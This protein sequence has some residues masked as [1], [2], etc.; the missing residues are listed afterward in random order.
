MASDYS[1]PDKLA[2]NGSQVPLSQVV[3]FHRIPLYPLSSQP[4]D[5]RGLL[6]TL[7]R[8]EKLWHHFRFF[9]LESLR[10]RAMIQVVS[11]PFLR[12]LALEAWR[13]SPQSGDG[14]YVVHF[15]GYRLTWSRIWWQEAEELHVTCNKAPSVLRTKWD[16]QPN[17]RSWA[18]LSEGKLASSP[19]EFEG[20]SRVK[21]V[22]WG[23]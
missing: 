23:F 19:T 15:Y 17:G 6:E 11:S 8:R 21:E 14:W 12:V 3:L 1:N 4:E 16:M 13:S 22:T 9:I 18:W 20:G 7:I 2:S 5:L 10:A